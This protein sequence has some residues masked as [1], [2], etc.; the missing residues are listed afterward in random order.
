MSQ[1]ETEC[2]TDGEEDLVSFHL[3]GLGVSGWQS[4][5][6]YKKNIILS[7]RIHFFFYLQVNIDTIVENYDDHERQQ[8]LNYNHQ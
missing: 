7:V 4:V 5:I 1:P 6:L 3:G 2:E 8:E